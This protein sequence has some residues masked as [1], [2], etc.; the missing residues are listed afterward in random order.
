LGIREAAPRGSGRTVDLVPPAGFHEVRSN[1]HFQ[2]CHVEANMKHLNLELEKLESRVAPTLL[3]IID[4]VLGGGGGGANDSNCSGGTAS[5][6]SN[7]CGSSQNSTNSHSHT[8]TKS[9][10]SKSGSNCS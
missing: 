1:R 7:S 4:V 2:T 8:N 10:A 3:P 6:G 9:S 5:N